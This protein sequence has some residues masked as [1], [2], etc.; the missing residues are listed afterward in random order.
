MCLLVYM[1]MNYFMN[2]HQKHGK[3]STHLHKQTAFI[4]S[5]GAHGAEKLLREA[6]QLTAR[7]LGLQVL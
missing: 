6:P 4:S 7:E 1:I 3:Q 5:M 2:I